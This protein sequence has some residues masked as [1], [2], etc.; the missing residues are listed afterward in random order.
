MADW[1]FVMSFRDV[2]LA[3]DGVDCSSRITGLV[4]SNED[5]LACHCTCLDRL[6]ESVAV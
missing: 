2:V 3:S 1:E 4:C 6:L 5:V